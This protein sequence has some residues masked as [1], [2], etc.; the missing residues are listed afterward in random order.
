MPPIRSSTSAASST[1]T[2]L[3]MLRQYNDFNREPQTRDGTRDALECNGSVSWAR[4]PPPGPP[5]GRGVPRAPTLDV[6][7]LAQREARGGGTRARKPTRAEYD[8]QHG[9]PGGRGACAAFRPRAPL[10]PL[11]PARE[12]PL[13]VVAL[14]VPARS[15]RD[16]LLGFLLAGV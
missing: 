9:E 16:L 4:V 6:E 13:P 7:R 2:T 5:V 15:R 12:L 10:R 3:A 8:A 14:A 1:T 11:V